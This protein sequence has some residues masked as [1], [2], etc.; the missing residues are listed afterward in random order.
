MS[1]CRKGDFGGLVSDNAL[2]SLKVSRDK[3]AQHDVTFPRLV[4]LA[5]SRD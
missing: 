2:L 4:A 1:L 3:M 5:M